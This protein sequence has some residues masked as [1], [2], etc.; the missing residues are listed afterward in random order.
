MVIDR[1]CFLKIGAQAALCSVFPATAIAS[2]G[3]SSAPKRKLFLF[4]AHTGEKLDVCYYAQGQ[5]QHEALE[6]INY[7]FRD[8]RTGKIKPIRK[9]LLNLL[10]SVSKKLDRPTRFHIIS[11]Y[12]S[13]ETNA[14][15]RKKSK[16]VVKN[17]L[18]TQGEAAD[19]RIPDCDTKW[20]RKVCM[21]LKAGGVGYYRKSDFV[22]VDV[23]PVRHWQI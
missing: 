19:I 5:Y 12:R 7:I 23:G 16:Y 14:E 11:G 15:L 22:H 13:P 4:N 17:S 18:H 3:R 9:E 20:L 2:I 8:Y 10:H 1:R 21:T 6:D